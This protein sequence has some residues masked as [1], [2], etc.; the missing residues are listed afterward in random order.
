[1]SIVADIE[2]EVDSFIDGETSNQAMLMVDMC[3]QR[4]NA[5]RR[6]D[7]ILHH[8]SVF[9]S[10]KIRNSNEYQQKLRISLCFARFYLSL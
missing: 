2:P 5:I 6:E 7:V 10:A 3:A 4:A 9:L 1:M 8:N